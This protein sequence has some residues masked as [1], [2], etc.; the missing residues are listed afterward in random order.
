[1]NKKSLLIEVFIAFLKLGLTSFGGP[2]AH[3]GY[4]RRELVERRAWVSE[5]QFSQL[6][7]I[8]QF[9]PGPAS[10]QLGFALGFL[11]AGALGAI[12]AFVAFTLP[13]AILL[14]A[15]ATALPLMSGRFAEAAISG[16]KIVTYAVVADAVLGMSKKLCPDATRRGI[17]IV[18]VIFL[19]LVDFAWMQIIVVLAGALAA[20]G[21]G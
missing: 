17:A 21:V 3:L 13:S 5:S 12:A 14:F 8:C 1:M 16:L 7:A 6:L 2:I 11:R 18:A 9:L 4:F 19:L 20:S 10:S 15:F